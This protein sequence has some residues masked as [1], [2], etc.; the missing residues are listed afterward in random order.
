[1]FWTALLSTVLTTA[2][3]RMGSPAEAPISEFAKAFASAR[4]IRL[5]ASSPATERGEILLWKRC[6]TWSV[7]PMPCRLVAV[8]KKS[9]TVIGASYYNLKKPRAFLSALAVAPEYRG[10]RIGKLLIAVSV[11]HML[12]AGCEGAE[13]H[14]LGVDAS[15]E[16]HGLYTSCGFL[17]GDPARG[18][19]YRLRMDPAG[20]YEARIL[21]GPSQK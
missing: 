4:G 21:S 6:V 13:L 8:D 3:V 10:R 19:T 9:G 17:G 14:V 15:V 7:N 18:G 20:D 5:E 1:M 11:A 12:R 16:R 2:A